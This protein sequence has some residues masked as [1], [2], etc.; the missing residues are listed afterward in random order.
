MQ[1]VVHNPHEKSEY[2]P[3]YWHKTQFNGRR[4]SVEDSKAYDTMSPPVRQNR[5][6]QGFVTLPLVFSDIT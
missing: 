6:A 4:H 5:I 3:I 2:L 1:K